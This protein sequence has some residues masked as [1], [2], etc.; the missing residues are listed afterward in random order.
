M[1]VLRG[2]RQAHQ[3]RHH[4][5]LH[6][7]SLSLRGLPRILESLHAL[8]SGLSAGA[9]PQRVSHLLVSDAG[10]PFSE[11]DDVKETR[12]ETTLRLE[13]KDRGGWAIK[14]LP[15]VSGLPDR[16]VLLPG[17]HLIFV[18]LKSP[19]GTVAP[20]QTVVHGRLRRLGFEVLVLASP[21]AVRDWAK[22]LDAN[23]GGND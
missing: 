12:V 22:G 13:I 10:E 14:L 18:E 2:E 21:Q 3:A 6:K 4:H 17:G 11:E 9:N 1:P 5:V 7:G 20:H 16:M 19:T 8:V 23:G 15:S